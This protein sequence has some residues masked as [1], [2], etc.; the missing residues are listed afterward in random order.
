MLEGEYMKNL[1][2]DRLKNGFVNNLPKAIFLVILYV[3][4]LDSD[5]N[6]PYFNLI[7]QNWEARVTVV[8][9]VGILM[10]RPSARTLQ[11][12]AITLFIIY[13]FLISIF[14]QSGFEVFGLMIYALLVML[15]IKLGKKPK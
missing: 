10:F 2:T 1:I 3:I 8:F 7:S 9:I 5:P 11:V 6:T 14:G 12:S 13:G 4:F 15:L